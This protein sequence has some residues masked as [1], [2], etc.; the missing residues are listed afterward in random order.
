MANKAGPYLIK[1]FHRMVLLALSATA[2]AIGAGM[3]ILAPLALLH[4]IGVIGYRIEDHDSTFW[5]L[6][7]LGAFWGIAH[8]L[9][10][11]TKSEAGEATQ[12]S[13]RFRLSGADLAQVP[14]DAW[15]SYNETYRGYKIHSFGLK[16]FTITA[17][18]GHVKK[19]ESLALAKS[20]ID[21]IEHA[22]GGR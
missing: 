21:M 1:M 22:E 10:T 12:A 7:V 15:T 3:V 19:V 6:A 16:E 20:W 5:T 14:P 13:G 2:G 18:D 11:I 9:D 4:E 8:M 17:P